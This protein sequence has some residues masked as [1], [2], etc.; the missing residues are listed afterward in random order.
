M[1]IIK[2]MRESTLYTEWTGYV[3]RKEE[4]EAARI[5][6]EL[7]IE[8]QRVRGRPKWRWECVVKADMEKGL[9]G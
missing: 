8:G 5:T 2:K 1:D 4:E 7:E 3:L 9:D 6:F